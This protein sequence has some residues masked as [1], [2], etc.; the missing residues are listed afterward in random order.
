MGG[1]SGITS[2]SRVSVQP[3][4]VKVSIKTPIESGVK[5]PSVA[6]SPNHSAGRLEVPSKSKGSAPKQ[7]VMSRPALTYCMPKVVSSAH[8]SI[9]V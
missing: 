6:R 4:A 5:S 1:A 8:P 9:V 3:V 7:V 2:I